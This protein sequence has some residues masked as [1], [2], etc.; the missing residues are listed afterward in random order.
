MSDGRDKKTRDSHHKA[1]RSKPTA[2]SSTSYAA[3]A[4]SWSTHSNA[5]SFPDSGTDDFNQKYASDSRK[6][7]DYAMG[8]TGVAPPGPRRPSHDRVIQAA[9]NLPGHTPQTASR[10][11]AYS[12]QL[13]IDGSDDEG[14]GGGSNHGHYSRNN[15]N[16]GGQA[17]S[18]YYGNSSSAYHPHSSGGQQSSSYYA[19]TSGGQGSSLYYSHMNGGQGGSSSYYGSG[20]Y[21]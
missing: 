6:K 7:R 1:P 3:S 15:Y 10:P 17:S 4:P 21:Q 2:A 5:G 13:N 9:S 8:H 12:T 11:V 14:Y 20:R 16:G 19:S 18:S